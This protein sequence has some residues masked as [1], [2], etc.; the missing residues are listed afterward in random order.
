[1][2]PICRQPVN[3]SHRK[4]EENHENIRASVRMDVKNQII[5]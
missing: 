4:E 5:A 2:P 3:Y 1:M